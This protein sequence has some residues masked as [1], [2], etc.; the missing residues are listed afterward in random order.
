MNAHLSGMS[1]KGAALGAAIDEINRVKE[2]IQILQQENEDIA[3]QNEGLK[4]GAKEGISNL[5]ELEAV[6]NDVEVLGDQ[7]TEQAEQ[8]KALLLENKRLKKEVALLEEDD[9]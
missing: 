4:E 8:L 3:E 1:G 5:P 9:E 2:R 6:Q 7:I